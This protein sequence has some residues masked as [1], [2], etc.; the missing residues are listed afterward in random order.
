M[1]RIQDFITVSL[2]RIANWVANDPGTALIV[3]VLLF[4]GVGTFLV[5]KKTNR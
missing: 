1:Q 5:L 4:V 3:F 2:G